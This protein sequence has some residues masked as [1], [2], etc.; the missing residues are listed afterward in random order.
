MTSEIV[1]AILDNDSGLFVTKHQNSQLGELGIDTKFF[2]TKSEAMRAI[3]AKPY[4]EFNDVSKNT[5]L[6]N[7]LAWW[8]LEKL[9]KTDRWHI[10]CSIKEFNDAVDNFKNLKV[11]PINLEYNQA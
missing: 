7:D 6:Q 11:V 5:R 3:E 10:D 8:L 1:Y 9:Y 4:F 2:E